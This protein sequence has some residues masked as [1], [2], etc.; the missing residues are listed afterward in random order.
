MKYAVFQMKD[1][2]KKRIP[3]TSEAD[4][5]LWALTRKG[6]IAALEGCF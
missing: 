2:G 6:E 4:V 1:G 3:A 5:T